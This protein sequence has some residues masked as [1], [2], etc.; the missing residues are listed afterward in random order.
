MAYNELK[1]WAAYEVLGSSNLN[2]NMANLDFLKTQVIVQTCQGRL[3][4]A[5]GTPITTTDQTAKTTVY[6]AP[7]H[8]NKIGLY[9]GTDETWDLYTF[10]ELSLS[11]SGYTANKNY[12]IWG[13]LNSGSP[14]LESLIWTDDTN[15]ATGLT[16]DNGIWVKSG[17]VTRRYLGTIRITGTAGQCEDSLAK[18]F[19]WN[20]HKRVK[21]ILK[22][23]ESTNSWLKS[24]SWGEANGGS[25]YGTSRV[26]I[27]IGVTED[28]VEAKVQAMQKYSGGAAGGQVGVGVDET[29]TNSAQL[30]NSVLT[31][32]YI[33]T[34]AF[35]QGYPGIGFHYLAW[36]EQSTGAICTFYGDEHGQSGLLGSLMA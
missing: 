30:Y 24:G 1:V 23:V 11:L 14:A 2:S 5:S 16:L 9:N 32:V 36:L 27:V 8:G 21:R 17:D 6:F 34:L 12:D 20:M 18:R 35:Y 10:S 33:P 13:Y 7:Y 4:L 19:V 29:G 26:G 31:T 15:R 25:T 22:A 28:T 3:T